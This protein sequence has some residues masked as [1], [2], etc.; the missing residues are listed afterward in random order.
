LEDLLNRFSPC[1]ILIDELVAYI[2]QFEEGK[3]LTGGTFGSNLSFIQALTEALKAVP[4]GVLL[5]SLPQ[6]GFKS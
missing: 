1:V 3:T 6:G 2:R 5:A 4:T